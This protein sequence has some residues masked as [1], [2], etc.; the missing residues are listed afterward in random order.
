MLTQLLLN[1]QVILLTM[2]LTLAIEAITLAGRCLLGIKVF[3]ST[4]DPMRRLT[5][6][7]RIHHGYLGLGGVLLG[8]LL[9][10]V[11]PQLALWC[12]VVGAA[13]LASDLI[14]HFCV[15]LPLTGDHEFFLTHKD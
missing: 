11:F 14:H 6:G 12:V 1:P 2:V 4:P 3:R 10:G 8:N 13:M 9:G 15:L 7:V 5:L